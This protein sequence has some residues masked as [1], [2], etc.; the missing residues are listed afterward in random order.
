MNPHD[1]D[2]S[3]LRIK[4]TRK[5]PK[6]EYSSGSSITCVRIAQTEKETDTELESEGEEEKKEE[7]GKKRG[8][9]MNDSLQVNHHGIICQ[10]ILCIICFSLLEFLFLSIM[11]LPSC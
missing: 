9:S 1:D 2:D 6:G 11:K 7:E 5:N 8:N 3:S 10:L 4:R